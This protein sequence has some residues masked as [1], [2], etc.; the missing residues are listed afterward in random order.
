M[1][2]EKMAFNENTINQPVT[3]SRGPATISLEVV[4]NGESRPS[5]WKEELLGVLFLARQTN[6]DRME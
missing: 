2:A 3:P 6:S 5:R 4:V 1:P